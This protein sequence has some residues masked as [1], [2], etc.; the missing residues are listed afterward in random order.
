MRTILLTALLIVLAGASAIAQVPRTVSFQGRARD[1]AGNY[2]NDTRQITVRIFDAATGGNALYSET[3]ST[4]F[5]RGSFGILIGLNQPGGIPEEVT[6]DKPL[7][8]EVSIENFNSG[9]PLSPRLRFASAPS[10][11]NAEIASTLSPGASIAGRSTNGII[12]IGNELGPGIVVQGGRYATIGLGIDSTAEHFVSGDTA[13]T[14]GTPDPGS[15]YRDNAPMAWALVNADGLI[16]ADF[17]IKSVT[18]LATGQ[19]EIVLDNAAV[20]V[21]NP[22]GRT[23][24]ALAPM[25]SPSLLSDIAAP[26]TAQWQFRPGAANQDRTIIVHTFSAPNTVPVATDVPFAITVFGRPQ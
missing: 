19:Y 20:M 22:K 2:P 26:V 7:W 24:P 12:E 18:K 6:F 8:L 25:I 14:A 3:Q 15:I 9:Q 10:A 5:D 13:G 16:L 1:A 21:A 17:G 4:K 23:V 11:M